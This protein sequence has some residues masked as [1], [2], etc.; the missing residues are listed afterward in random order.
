LIDDT[1]SGAYRARPREAARI[2]V[3]ATSAF[4]NPSAVPDPARRQ[5]AA[6]ELFVIALKHA[7]ASDVASTI[8]S[9]F[10]RS[11]APPSGVSGGSRAPTL[12]DELRANQI[13]P[14]D[15]PLPQTMP[16]TAGRAATLTG[17][18]TIV[19]DAR[20]NNL[21][22]RANRADL[23]LI[24]AAVEQIDVRPAQVLIEVLI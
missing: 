21:L 2:T 23:E 14:V 13:P 11:S 1:L 9:L 18:L 8:N 4:S 5:S 17:E 24:R 22:V 20:A 12:S 3:P 19:A 10:G 6:P 7:R 16:G 15:A